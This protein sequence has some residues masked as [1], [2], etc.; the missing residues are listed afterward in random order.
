MPTTHAVNGGCVLPTATQSKN[1][2]I[3]EPHGRSFNAKD[4]FLSPMENTQSGARKER[5]AANTYKLSLDVEVWPVDQARPVKPAVYRAANIS[6]QEFQF[7]SADSFDIH[8]K[9]SFAVLFPKAS[10]GKA[11][12]LIVGTARIVRRTRVCTLDNQC[13]VLEA[14]IEQIRSMWNNEEKPV[15]I[16]KKAS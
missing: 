14:R 9:F 7:I 3:S 10:T 4:E 15:P 1:Q 12:S 13:F 6:L 8:R 5:G 11:M 2:T 16:R